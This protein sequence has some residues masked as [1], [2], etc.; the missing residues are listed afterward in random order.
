MDF[1]F[2]EDTTIDQINDIKKKLKDFEKSIKERNKPKTITI[3]GKSHEVIKKYCSQLNLK[4]GDW[5]EDILQKEID[6]N[7]AVFI[8]E[9]NYEEYIEKECEKL[10]DK[11]KDLNY[12]TWSIK[13][14]KFILL[15]N[16]KFLGYHISDGMPMYKYTGNNW[17][18][19]KERIGDFTIVKDPDCISK[20]IIGSDDFNTITEISGSKKRDKFEVMDYE[21]YPDKQS[22]VV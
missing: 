22:L 12:V 5:V 17:E 18:I 1:N 14:D 13:I 20:S 11:Y 21:F 8:G 3:S 10:V 2:T 15:K 4:I 19:E 16:F 9:E 7:S 6:N